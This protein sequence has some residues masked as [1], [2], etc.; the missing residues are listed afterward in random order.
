[1]KIEKFGTSDLEEYC[2]MVDFDEGEIE[3]FNTTEMWFRFFDGDTIAT[4]IDDIEK[5]VYGIMGNHP[6]NTKFIND[7]FKILI[8]NNGDGLNVHFS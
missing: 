4:N 5:G 8:D 3:N 6:N 1:M 7:R 2:K